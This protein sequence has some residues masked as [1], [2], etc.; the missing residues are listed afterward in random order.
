MT[1][2]AGLPLYHVGETPGIARFEPR[3]SAYT[4]MPVV[5]AIAPGKL[6]NYLLPRDCPRVTFFA[7][8]DSHPD[9]VARFMPE[10][11]PVVAIEAGWLDRV[12]TAQLYIY[13]FSTD[14]FVSHDHNAGYFVSA[15]AVTPLGMAVQRDLP[16]ALA[17]AGAELRVLPGLW[18]LHDAVKASSLGFSMLR[19]RNA[20]PRE[21]A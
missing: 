7:A 20:A 11:R 14:G 16:G 5:W 1:G 4:P 6:R 2:G 15:A 8:P 17:A 13:R 9:D 18:A 10:G 3:P 21:V 19:M 12:E